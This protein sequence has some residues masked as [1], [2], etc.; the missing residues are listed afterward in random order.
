VAGYTRSEPTGS[1][2]WRIVAVGEVVPGFNLPVLIRRASEWIQQ[3]A[4]GDPIV[5]LL[6][7]PERYMHCFWLK[8]DD[9]DSIIVI[10]MPTQFQHL[11]RQKIY[12]VETFANLIAQ[13]R[14]IS[15]IPP[16]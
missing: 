12:D 7:I 4:S 16:G 15:G 6:V 8:Y 1:I 14:N 3:N 9:R 2:D 10:D 13:E 5:R 11:E